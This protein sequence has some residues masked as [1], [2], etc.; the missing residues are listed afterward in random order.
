MPDN[1][2]KSIRALAWKQSSRQHSATAWK[3]MSASTTGTAAK[4]LAE[5]RALRRLGNARRQL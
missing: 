3:L 5:L 1:Q 4:T 2:Q